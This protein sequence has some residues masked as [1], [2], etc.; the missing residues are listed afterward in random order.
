MRDDEQEPLLDAL[1]HLRHN[2]HEVI[3][4]HTFHRDREMLLDYDKRPM[5]FVDLETGRTLRLNPAELA[6]QYGDLMLRQQA[7]L[8]QRAMQYRINYI[9]VDVAQGF[10]QII[11]PFLLKRSKQ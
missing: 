7:D 11:L 9:P 3:L 6:Q 5:R 2:R 8:Q 1:R 10:H 4:F